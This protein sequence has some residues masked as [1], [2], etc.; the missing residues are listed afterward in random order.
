MK[1][2]I[3]KDYSALSKRAA[4]VLGAI[5]REKPDCVLGLA[6]G[7]TP[8]GVY[9]E[10]INIRQSE[11]L[12]F[13]MVK[14]FNLDEYCGLNKSDPQSYHYY[15]WQNFFSQVNVK[16]E[17]IFIPDG[18]CEDV[19]LECESYDQAINSRGGMDILLLGLGRN[20]HIGF[21]EPGARLIVDTHMVK[22]SWNTIK[23]NARFFAS[24]AKVPGYA[25]TMGIGAIMKAKKILLVVSGADKADI[26]RKLMNNRT[27]STRIPAS[28]L[29]LH[30]DVTVLLDFKMASALGGR[31]SYEDSG[32]ELPHYHTLSGCR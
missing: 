29:H 21:N 22:L 19:A 32:Q 5:I 31:N 20:G 28:I 26:V 3:E 14:T 12:D 7:S 16:P 10:L 23:A 18:N 6:T 11:G 8:L 2:L 30:Q 15:M 1:L 27:I 24:E 13:S 25:I 9:Q 4:G 17:N